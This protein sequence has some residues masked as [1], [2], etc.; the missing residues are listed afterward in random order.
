M[1]A[2]ALTRRIAR[3]QLAARLPA[4]ARWYSSA[5]TKF[6][7]DGERVIHEKLT[8][9]FKPSELVVEDVSGGCGTFYQIIIASDEFK[10]LPLVKQQRLVNQTLKEEIQG[11]HGLQLKTI[12]PK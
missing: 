2:L 6:S 9:K 1:L 12:A 3:P 5:Q 7:T 4:V 8:E 11:I 10:G